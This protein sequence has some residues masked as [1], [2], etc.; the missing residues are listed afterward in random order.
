MGPVLIALA[1][2]LPLAVAAL[3]LVFE[4]GTTQ[5]PNGPYSQADLKR[6]S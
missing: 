4:F 2:V 1:A 6:P 3:A 5:G